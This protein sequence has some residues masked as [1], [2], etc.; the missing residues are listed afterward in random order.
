MFG[1]SKHQL[2]NGILLGL[3]IFLFTQLWQ[4][5]EEEDNFATVSSRQQQSEKSLL[6]HGGHKIKF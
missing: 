6:I 4:E 1:L 3:I 5:F 2:K